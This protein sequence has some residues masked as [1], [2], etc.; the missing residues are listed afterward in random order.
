MTRHHSF[1]LSPLQLAA[2]LAPTFSKSTLGGCTFPS[3]APSESGY[4]PSFLSMSFS[5]PSPTFGNHTR[6]QLPWL[7]PLPQDERQ[8]IKESQPRCSSFTMPKMKTVFSNSVCVYIL[9]KR[10]DVSLQKPLLK[11][12]VA[13]LA[14]IRQANVSSRS[15]V[16]V[17]KE[18]LVEDMPA[19]KEEKEY[20][21]A[22][23][24]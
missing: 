17:D 3:P 16:V 7:L 20:K 11:N 21:D 5:P 12:V 23:K 13:L 4:S 8:S 2:F 24:D 19:S 18:A 10:G 6:K 1:Y 9:A 15:E 22:E 14:N